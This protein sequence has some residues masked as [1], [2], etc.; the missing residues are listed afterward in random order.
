MIWAQKGSIA[1]F[2]ANSNKG[3]TTSKKYMRNEIWSLISF[4]NAPSWFI[5]YSPADVKHPIP[6]YFADTKEKFTP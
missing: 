5:T 6:L 1:I 2:I 3:S 4:M